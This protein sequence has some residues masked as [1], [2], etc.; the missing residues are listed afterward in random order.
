MRYMNIYIIGSLY[1]IM[2]G[3]FC[4]DGIIS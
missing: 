2:F 3:N 4:S 1:S